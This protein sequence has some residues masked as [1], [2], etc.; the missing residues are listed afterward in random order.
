[1]HD[2]KNMVCALRVGLEWLRE[3]QRDDESALA[4][5]EMRETCNAL[6][7]LLLDALEQ[8]RAG[9]SELTL[10]KRPCWLADVVEQSARKLRVR[11]A[12][13]GVTVLAECR[14]RP[15]LVV[16][17]DLLA[18]VLENL[19]DNALRVSPTGSVITLGCGTFGESAVITVTDLG[20]GVDS[21]RQDEIFELYS[22]DE[23]TG[24]TGIG[25]PFCRRVVEAHGGSLTLD[26]VPG[27]GATFL[28]SLPLGG[29]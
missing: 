20:P 10:K 15:N 28:I 25:L 16:D 4:L 14:S 29:E 27:Q 7:R 18:R 13:A 24:G 9:E 12:R 17:E 1:L 2:A 19:T 3:T 8:T 6:T 22:R 11:A 5:D 23:E 26:S 21:A